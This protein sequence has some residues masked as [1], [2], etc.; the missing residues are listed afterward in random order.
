MKPGDLVRLKPSLFSPDPGPAQLVL[1]V[2][3]FRMMLMVKLHGAKH[4]YEANLF[5]VVSESR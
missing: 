5:E 1:K 3:V 2:F 4:P